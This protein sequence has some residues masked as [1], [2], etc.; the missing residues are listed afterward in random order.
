[1]RKLKQLTKKVMSLATKAKKTEPEEV[2]NFP[3][4]YYVIG[5]DLGL[6]R[7]GFCKLTVEKTE[8]KVMLT[9]IKLMSVDNKND[10]KKVHGE[11]IDEIMKAFT[12]FIPD[13]DKEKVPCFYIREKEIMNQKLPSERDIS[14]I[15]GMTDWI[16]WRLGEIWRNIYPVTVKKWIAGNGKASKEDVANSLPYYVGNLNYAN[17]DESDATAVAI[18]WL[19]QQNQLQPHISES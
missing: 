1:M 11:L 16:L 19:L 9:D 8:D 14:K 17:D 2:I 6:K 7:P 3:Q 12:A 5:A 13:T 18:A 15:V 4:K 10:R